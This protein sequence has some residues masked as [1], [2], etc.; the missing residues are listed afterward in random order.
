MPNTLRKIQ[1]VSLSTRH[2]SYTLCQQK[3]FQFHETAPLSDRSGWFT[4]KFYLRIHAEC[5][6][7]DPLAETRAIGGGR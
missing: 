2:D 3:P 1:V 5:H 4:G 6:F 7:Y